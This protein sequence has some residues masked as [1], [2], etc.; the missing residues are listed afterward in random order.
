MDLKNNISRRDFL[1]LSGLAAGA[2]LLPLDKVSAATPMQEIWNPGANLGRVA[3]GAYRSFIDLK[4]EPNVNAANTTRVWRD[5]VF[6][7]KREV[8]ANVLD[9]NRYNQKWY[10]TPEGYIYSPNVQPVKYLPNAPLMSLPLDDQGNPGMWVEITVPKVE[11]ELTKAWSQ[12]SSWIRDSEYQAKLYYAQVYWAS[13]IRINNGQTEYLLSE[14]YGA[15]PDYYWVDARAC[16]PITAEEIT[17]IHPDVGDKSVLVNLQ[18][19]TM[20]CFE[21]NQE[22]YFAEVST[23]YKRDGEWLTPPGKTPVWR[24]M[25]SLHMSAG[26][27]SEFDSPGIGWTT[28]F[29][30]QGQ[31]IHAVYWHNNYG[32]ALSHG[33][34]NCLPHDAK[35][36]YRWINPQVGLLPG[37][38]TVQGAANSTYVEVIES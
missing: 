10:E 9:Y 2:L 27:V 36:V 37:E 5:D 11:F 33:C 23:G 21:G 31:A 19:Q 35:W 25:V 4:A 6:E 30:P 16:R 18:K 7:I 34:V 3:M 29:H 12:A 38:L 8:V 32:V 28:L 22:V 14:K 24:K 15:L 17:P 20:Q 1:K 26:G 13:D